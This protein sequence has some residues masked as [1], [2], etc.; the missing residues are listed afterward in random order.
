MAN[1]LHPND[2]VLLRED[3]KSKSKDFNLN[4]L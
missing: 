2:D 1:G 3:N 4:S